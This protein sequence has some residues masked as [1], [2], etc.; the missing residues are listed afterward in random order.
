RGEGAGKGVDIGV[1]GAVPAALEGARAAAIVNHRRDAA[2]VAGV[3]VGR[4]AV[5]DEA[6]AAVALEIFALEGLP[7]V[8]GL[9]L[10]AG[11]VGDALDDLA[12][13]NL[14]AARQA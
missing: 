8:G 6:E 7:D 13:L 14:E 9:Q 12:E 2:H 3:H 10:L 11:L 4:R 1:D 5:L